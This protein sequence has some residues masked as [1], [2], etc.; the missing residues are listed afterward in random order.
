MHQTTRTRQMNAA[1]YVYT[2]A[3]LTPAQAAK[4]KAWDAANRAAVLSTTTEKET[5]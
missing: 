1:G 2:G 4:V 3:W 5:K